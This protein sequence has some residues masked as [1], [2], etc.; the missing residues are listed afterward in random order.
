MHIMMLEYRDSER[1]YA[2]KVDKDQRTGIVPAAFDVVFV[3]DDNDVVMW[4]KQHACQHKTTAQGAENG[5]E[6]GV[7][8]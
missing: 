8:H 2:G 6:P 3:V 1:E 7:N 4:V 5:R